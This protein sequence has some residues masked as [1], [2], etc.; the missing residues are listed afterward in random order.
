M[1]KIV[2]LLVNFITVMDLKDNITII[3]IINKEIVKEKL[4][5][6]WVIM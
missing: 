3:I 4:V 5:I 2:L 1:N 6:L